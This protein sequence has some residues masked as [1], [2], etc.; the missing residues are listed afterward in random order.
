MRK[1]KTLD[2]FSGIGGFAYALKHVSKVVAYCEKSDDCRRVLES[3]MT[4][5]LI[6]RAKVF[7]DV[8]T[9]RTHD[10][11]KDIAMIT[12]GFPCQDISAAN[13]HGKGLKGERSGLV[14]HVFRLMDS[15]PSVNYVILEN[16]PCIRTR[17]LD[18]LMRMFKSRKFT[19][20][21]AIV[22]C[23][24][25][26]APMLRKRWFC[27]ATR[28]G[29]RDPVVS[30]PIP[31]TAH[32]W[33]AEPVPRLV[34]KDESYTANFRRLQML[35]NAVV[36]Q[37]LQHAVNVIMFGHNATTTPKHPGIK[38]ILRQGRTLYTLHKWASPS[39]L[40]HQYNILTS[41]STQLLSNQIF[42]DEFTKTQLPPRTRNHHRLSDIYSINPHWAEWLMGYPHGFTTHA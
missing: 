16:S 14:K 42:Y 33:S 38:I 8:Q 5:K 2:L 27:I 30:K 29:V 20:Q 32:D 3:N 12:A 36:P 1:L 21:W 31:I 37:C 39:T 22:G 34:T 19:C 11:P 4:K 10:L 26:G 23:D 35:G 15:L 18:E 25:V 7:N 40:W 9:L 13:P 28:N 24:E 41:R 6:P 17:G